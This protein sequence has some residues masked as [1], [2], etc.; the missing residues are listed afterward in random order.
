LRQLLGTLF[1]SRH[2]PRPSAVSI[3]RSA[4]R[5]GLQAENGW[6]MTVS[7]RC[8]L[9]PPAHGPCVFGEKTPGLRAALSGLCELRRSASFPRNDRRSG[10][11]RDT[12]ARPAALPTGACVFPCTFRSGAGSRSLDAARMVVPQDR[13]QPQLVIRIGRANESNKETHL[14][15]Y[16]QRD[17]EL[18][19]ADRGRVHGVDFTN[20]ER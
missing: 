10:S 17:R 1:W 5:R 18:A 2:R 14:V 11:S 7:I 19:P 13:P 9:F 20:G 15:N 12:T 4:F 6:C 8:A 3:P 16:H